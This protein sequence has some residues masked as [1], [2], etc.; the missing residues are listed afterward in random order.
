MANQLEEAKKYLESNKNT[1]RQEELIKGLRQAGYSEDVIREATGPTPTS[2]DVP[3]QK[4]ISTGRKIGECVL[5]FIGTGIVFQLVSAIAGAVLGRS[6][7][8][9]SYILGFIVVIAGYIYLRKKRKYIA[10]GIL[11][12]LI[13]GVLLVGAVFLFLAVML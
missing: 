6:Q 1:Y 13:V 8:F 3:Q 10:R 2:A 9:I 11:G 4:T 12:S 5:G 7:F